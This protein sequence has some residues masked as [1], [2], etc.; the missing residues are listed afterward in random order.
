[1]RTT[2]TPPSPRTPT[3]VRNTNTRF[4]STKET[5][6]MQQRKCENLISYFSAQIHSLNEELEHE[7]QWR[8]THLAKIVKALLCFEAKL[9]NDQR[10]IRHQLY[11]KDT[12]L[13]RLAREV[14]ALREKYGVK[15]GDTIKIDDIAQYCPNCRKQY[16]HLDTKD[17][18]IQVVKHEL[19]CANGAEKGN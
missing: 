1:M 3:T 16:Y 8:D 18:S 14:V 2:N 4:Q 12:E 9:K 19:S 15:D 10:Q 5:I 6:E 11:E 13:N 7:K 17:V